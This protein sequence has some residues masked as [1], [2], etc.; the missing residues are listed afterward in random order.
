MKFGFSDTIDCAAAYRRHLLAGAAMIHGLALAT[1]ASAQDILQDQ[2]TNEGAQENIVVTGSRIA[3]DGAQA[4]TPVSIISD[5][6]VRIE[7]PA[8]VADFVNTLPAVQGSQTAVTNSGSLSNGQSGISALNLRSLGQT[9]TLVLIDGQRSVGSTS[10][11]LV[12]INTIPQALISRVEVVTGGASSVYGSD[13][14]AGVVNFILKKDFDGIEANYQYGVTTYSDVPNHLLQFTAGTKFAEGRGSVVF[15]AEYFNQTGQHTIAR[16]WQDAGFFRIENPNRTAGQP[17]LFVGP[18]IGSSNITPGGLIVSGP[19]RGTYFG[20]T[21]LATGL[22]SVNQLN[23]GQVSGQWMI[24]GDIDVTTQGHRSSNSLANDEERLSLFGRASYEITPNF[25]VFAQASYNR[26]DG[27]SFYQQT[28]TANY[29]IALDNAFLPP[30]FLAQVEQF[31]ANR[32]AGTAAV[33]QI[34]IGTSNAGIP[35]AGANNTREVQRFVIGADGD[36]SIAGSSFNWNAYYQHG[37]T[38]ANERLTNTWLNSRINAMTDAVRAPD[39]SIQCRVNVDA[40]PNNDLPGCVPINRIG[41]G[42]VTQEALDY[43]FQILPSREQYIRQDVVAANFTTSRLFDTW[44]GPVALGFGGEYRGDSVDGFIDPINLQSFLYGNFRVTTGKVD[45]IEG[46]AE[47]VIPL[48]FGLEANGAVRITNYSTSGTVTTWKGGLIWQPIDDLRFRATRSRDIR[49]PNLLELFDAGTARTNAVNIPLP[50]GGFRADEF[51][52]NLTGN[53]DLSPEIA[54]TLGLGVVFTPTFVPD[55]S[56]SLDYFDIDITGA[57][58]FVSAQ[59]VVDLC[60]LQNQTSFCSD[61]VFFPGTD[62]VDRINLRPVNFSSQ[63]TRGFDIEANYRTRIGAGDLLLRAFG[64]YTI[65][66]IIDNGF[67]VDDIAGVNAGGG[68][69]TFNYRFNAGYSFDSGLSALFVFRGFSDGVYDN[70][71][72]ECSGNCPATGPIARTINT[73]RIKGIMYTDANF[74]YD[75]SIGRTDAQL[76]FAIKN[77]FDRDPVLVG[78]GPSGNNTPAY[79]QTNRGLYDTFGRTFRVGLRV[80]I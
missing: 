33:T 28:P 79:P 1:N 49:A 59:Q 68:I 40:N 13:A 47:T 2:T 4:P 55:L 72:I 64:T 56:V 41:V 8:N 12:D 58:S 36:F 19:F 65:N 57:I 3:R 38:N 45:V 73:N 26:F 25:E 51:V 44:A 46:Y 60:Y 67:E 24:G 75:F 53:T 6:E 66:N 17:E 52:Q 42:G 35:A 31:N 18:G 7:A 21:N 48:G 14:V 78:N 43:L 30:E 9:R 27:N 5:A 23:F 37:R 16:K 22:A 62:D 80:R 69:P 61:I 77:L 11:G 10:T 20:T 34:L 32:P 70:D 50:G 63:K 29:R 39:G 71:W 15:A 54:S 76:S 74:T